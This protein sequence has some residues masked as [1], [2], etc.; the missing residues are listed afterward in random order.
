MSP[1][2]YKRMTIILGVVC[3]CLLAWCG[4]LLWNQGWLSIRVA[5]ASEQTRIFDEMRAKALKS[6][7]AGAAGCLQYVVSYYPS[8]TKQETG[9]RLD[10]I[11]ERERALAIRDIVA[12]LRTKT[13]DDLG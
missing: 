4:A 2:G 1:A 12:Y 7:A 13:G 8:G 9:S 5:L 6:D 3:L 11:V 10:Q